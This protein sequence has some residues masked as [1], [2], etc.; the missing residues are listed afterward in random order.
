MLFKDGD[1]WGDN[2]K[3]QQN[4]EDHFSCRIVPELSCL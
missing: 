3:K 2:A 1:R 4:Y